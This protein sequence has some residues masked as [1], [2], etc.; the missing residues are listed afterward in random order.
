MRELINNLDK[1]ERT[2]YEHKIFNDKETAFDSEGQQ[3][4]NQ[5]VELYTAL[6]TKKQKELDDL[7]AALLKIEKDFLAMKE[8]QNALAETE[9][10][11]NKIE[12]AKV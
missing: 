8:Y 9:E 1:T 3:R 4:H 7:K 5:E 11:R 2:H 6:K 12:D 10:L